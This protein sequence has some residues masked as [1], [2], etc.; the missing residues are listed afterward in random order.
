M[1]PVFVSWSG[2]KDSCFACYRAIASGLKVS[3]LVNTV[4]EDGKRSWTHGLPVEL[5]HMQA[6]AVGI[7]LIQRPM[8]M[9]NYETN[10]KDTLLSLKQEGITGGVFGD[11]DIEGHKE[12]IDK[13]SQQVN[14]TP[15]L[16]LWGS[17]QENLLRDFI[18]SGFEAIVVVA[19]AELFGEEILGRTVDQDFLRH[20]EELRKT[21][22]VTLCGEA[23]EYHTF[24]V[25]GPIFRRKIEILES[26]KPDLITKG[27]NYP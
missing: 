4:T 13:M 12:W 21:K 2:G 15:Y 8:T 23:G 18:Q 27:S 9:A 26:R 20:L 10:F 22:N 11:I 24:V 3:Y 19:K 14:I 16:P 17:N 5:L 1:N 25:D 7:P 6:Q